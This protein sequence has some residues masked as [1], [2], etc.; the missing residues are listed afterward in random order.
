VLNSGNVH[1]TLI[2]S[3][4]EA[5]TGTNR[6]LPLPNGRQVVVSIPPGVNHG[7]VIRLE[8]Y[9]RPTTYNNPV[10]TL[11]VTIHIAPVIAV[12]A[13]SPA[14]STFQHTVLASNS[15]ALNEVKP[16]LPSVPLTKRQGK[17]NTK[18]HVAM[19]VMA[20]V[21]VL[22]LAIIG[23]NVVTSIIANASTIPYPSYLPGNGTLALYDPMKD[24]SK[25]YSWSPPKFHYCNFQ[26]GTLHVKVVGNDT[27]P[28]YFRP[29]VGKTQIFIDF[30]Y[31]VKMRFVS[32]DCGG[33][34]FRSQ[35]PDHDPGMYVFYICQNSYFALK[36]YTQNS[37]DPGVNPILKEGNSH[38][39]N[40]GSSKVNIIAVVA[41]G[42]N[43]SLYVNQ[44]Q[45]VSV[46]DDT[47]HQGLIGVL[48]R[49][50]DLSR[51]AEAAF[52]DAIVWTL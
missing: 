37:S 43:V 49:T 3:A 36:R 4:L 42:P 17:H 38:F 35:D 31:Q 14:T 28:A 24:D 20:F 29:C 13:A 23:F 46:R 15:L 26:G 6:V 11:I 18:L 21:L 5:R 2:I 47:F 1:Q 51:S 8:G 52:S 48:A 27:S 50:F 12:E 34:T 9:G 41:R 44:Q 7:Q 16:T 22:P 10:G 32:G 30:A 40:V 25:G 33:I 19:A 45:M 39:I